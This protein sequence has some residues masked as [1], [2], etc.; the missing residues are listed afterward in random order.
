MTYRKDSDIQWPYGSFGKRTSP[1]TAK[2][3]LQLEDSVRKKM[4]LV[5]GYSVLVTL[6]IKGR[7]T[8]KNCKAIFKWTSTELVAAWI[9]RVILTKTQPLS[10]SKG[11]NH[12]T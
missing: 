1:V 10:A 3:L 12:A 6:T 4:K 8:W 11:Q 5:A 7:S 9:V 2:E